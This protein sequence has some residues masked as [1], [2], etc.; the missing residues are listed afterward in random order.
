MIKPEDFEQKP[1]KSLLCAIMDIIDI[2]GGNK[3]ASLSDTDKAGTKQG[4]L[5]V[6]NYTAYFLPSTDIKNTN[7]RGKVIPI[8]THVANPDNLQLHDM[9]RSMIGTYCVKLPENVKG[10]PPSIFIQEVLYVPGSESLSLLRTITE[11]EYT[12][13]D[14]SLEVPTHKSALTP[15]FRRIQP[16]QIILPSAMPLPTQL[17]SAPSAQ[18]TEPKRQAKNL[19]DDLFPMCCVLDQDYDVVKKRKSVD[20]FTQSQLKCSIQ[21]F[22]CMDDQPCTVYLRREGLLCKQRVYLLPVVALHSHQQS[23]N[24]LF[25]STSLRFLRAVKR[26]SVCGNGEPVDCWNST[27]YQLTQDSFIQECIMHQDIQELALAAVAK[28]VSPYGWCV[29]DNIKLG[30]SPSSREI[31]DL[32]VKLTESKIPNAF[33]VSE[34]FFMPKQTIKVCLKAWQR[35]LNDAEVRRRVIAK[36]RIAIE[37]ELKQTWAR[38][39]ELILEYV[40]LLGDIRRNKASHIITALKFEVCTERNLAKAL[41]KW[42]TLVKTAVP[43]TQ[44]MTEY[45]RLI[46]VAFIQLRSHVNELK[47]NSRTKKDFKV[48]A[49]PDKTRDYPTDDPRK[50]TMDDLCMVLAQRQ[51]PIASWIKNLSSL[52]LCEAWLFNTENIRRDAACTLLGLEEG[53][54]CENKPQLLRE[55]VSQN[56][57]TVQILKLFHLEDKLSTALVHCLESTSTNVWQNNV[58]ALM[59][60]K[61][62]TVKINRVS[63]LTHENQ[64]TFPRTVERDLPTSPKDPSEGCTHTQRPK[65]SRRASP[66]TVNEDSTEDDDCLES[67]VPCKKRGDVK[68]HRRNTMMFDGEQSNMQVEDSEPS[69]EEGVT[70]KDNFSPETNP[71]C[72]RRPRAPIDKKSR[73]KKNRYLLDEAKETNLIMGSEDSELSDENYTTESDSSDDRYTQDSFINDDPTSS[74]TSS[75]EQQSGRV[76]DHNLEFFSNTKYNVEHQKQTKLSKKRRH[77]VSVDSEDEFKVPKKQ[78]SNRTKRDQKCTVSLTKTNAEHDETILRSEYEPS[79]GTRVHSHSK[80]NASPKSVQIDDGKRKVKKRQGKVKD[81]SSNSHTRISEN[82]NETPFNKRACP[83]PQAIKGDEHTAARSY[84]PK[85]PQQRALISTFDNKTG[86]ESPRLDRDTAA[87]SPQRSDSPNESLNTYEPKD[88]FAYLPQ[89]SEEQEERQKQGELFSHLNFDTVNQDKMFHLPVSDYSGSEDGYLQ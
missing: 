12:F 33:A 67:S 26:Q 51:P 52:L 66:A 48:A 77:E 47:T 55:W 59:H 8:V 81:K 28:R 27:L 13:W 25:V 3:L 6:S 37:T 71:W 89:E 46:N 69:D 19:S 45:N 74:A 70:E 56:R 79:V 44:K 42:E 10:E 64:S 1:S 18:E 20:C 78:K 61:E 21:H 32:G 14:M 60:K 17:L 34:L 73:K 40:A 86:I 62:H 57:A 76:S 65:N 72:K 24:T 2:E 53:L 5:A 16:S 82:L 35:Y 31:I 84:V 87:F 75:E 9:N 15:C 43:K 7:S 54:L 36:R 68:Q 11:D 41:H 29:I 23:K 4:L 58:A 83:S 85:G 39:E 22:S 30:I 50:R 63:N 49:L 88:N 80:H 38:L